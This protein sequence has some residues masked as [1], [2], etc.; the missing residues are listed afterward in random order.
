M[1]RILHFTILTCSALYMHAQFP[2]S[3]F[4]PLDSVSFNFNAYTG[5][6]FQATPTAGQL[7]SSGFSIKPG[8]TNAILNFNGTQTTPS[9]IYTRGTTANAVTTAGYY[10]FRVD[11]LDTTNKA[12]GFQQ[13]G[14]FMGGA[15][16]TGEVRLRFINATAKPIYKLN[17]S[18][19]M[20]V[21]NDATRGTI[22]RLK[23]GNDTNSLANIAGGSY[24]SPAAGTVGTAWVL[25]TSYNLL[26]NNVNIP[27]GGEYIFSY[28][29]KDSLGTGSRDE[30]AIDNFKLKAI[31]TIIVNPS[32]IVNANFTASSVSICKGKTVSFNNTTTTIPANT[33]L[34]YLWDFKDGGADSIANPIHQFD[35]VGTF[36]VT[37]YAFDTVSFALDSHVVSIQVNPIPNANFTISN[38]G[39]AYSFSASP[40][41]PVT[42]INQW[43]LNG[44]SV[45]TAA[46]YTNVFNTGGSKTVCLKV[47]NVTSGCKDSICQTFSVVLP[48]INTLNV[49]IAVSDSILCNGDSAAL[50]AVNITGGT[51]PYV[52]TWT[53]NGN[54]IPAPILGQN[55][56]VNNSGLLNLVLLVTDSNNFTKTDTVKILVLPTPNANFTAT[57][58]AGNALQYIINPVSPN[59]SLNYTLFVNGTPTAL[60]GAAPFLYTF[61]N[62]G[63]YAV[64]LKAA[65]T[66]TT[67]SDSICQSVTVIASG[68][69]KIG[70]KQTISV[71]PNPAKDC[72]NIENI[73]E[74]TKV[75]IYNTVGQL[76]RLETLSANTKLN[77]SALQAGIYFVALNSMNSNRTIRLVIQ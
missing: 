66:T 56:V 29:I 35:S 75:K 24:L 2:I 73:S 62:S 63:T 7:S 33:P 30:I 43:Y 59:G 10:A 61:S 58:S 60:I 54:S 4:Y 74:K 47:T 9:T 70:Q 55:N 8:G 49:A 37:L 67:C 14:T 27:I 69:S 40:S 5:A 11:P 65:N 46:M 16:I 51:P 25:D 41:Q 44:V 68:L 42:L 19:D 39:A 50:T 77:I 3:N 34:L 6:G 32:V 76:V 53:V 38:V 28:A 52:S 17:L 64:C 71:Y 20:Y 1:K 21:R 13:T 23:G 57:P 72:L 12:F 36:N 22:I 26:I 15:N 31:D 45:S 48:P 18:Y